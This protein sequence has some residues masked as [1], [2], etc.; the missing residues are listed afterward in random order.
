MTAQ[1]QMP[2]NHEDLQNLKVSVFLE[3]LVVFVVFGS[4]FA[5]CN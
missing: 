5:A 1:L 2:L 3:V 4:A